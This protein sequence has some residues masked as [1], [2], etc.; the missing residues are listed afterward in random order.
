MDLETLVAAAKA[1]V[2]V[3]ESS[4]DEHGEEDDTLVEDTPFRGRHPQIAGTKQPI[5][6]T[7]SPVPSDRIGSSKS[8]QSTNQHMEGAEG[9]PAASMPSPVLRGGQLT[10]DLYG[11]EGCPSL[12]PSPTNESNQAPSLVDDDEDYEAHSPSLSSSVSDDEGEVEPDFQ[13]QDDEPSG[14][15]TRT[16][17]SEF[18]GTTKERVLSPQRRRPS[19][20]RRSIGD[21]EEKHVSFVSPSPAREVKI[22]K[23][24]NDKKRKRF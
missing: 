4:E 9:L 23:K 16:S 20:F 8:N 10:T 7:M 17:E 24:E 1:P 11:L 13:I 21:R 15:S 3:E 2:I 14:P 5:R 18:T 6:S 19:A 12:E 22:S